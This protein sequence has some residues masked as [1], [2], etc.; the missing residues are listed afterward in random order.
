MDTHGFKKRDSQIPTV[1]RKR[2]AGVCRV[3]TKEGAANGFQG[4]NKKGLSPIDT[5]SRKGIR[6]C[7]GTRKERAAL[8]RGE[9]VEGEIREVNEK[10]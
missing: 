3:S 6:N 5:C 10:G 1:P 2:N 4:S 9:V 8:E 7:M